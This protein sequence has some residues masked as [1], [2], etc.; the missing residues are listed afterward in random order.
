MGLMERIRSGEVLVADGA[1]GTLLQQRGMPPGSCPELLNLSQEDLVASVPRDYA[2]A[3]SDMVYTNSFGGN[4]IRL[5]RCGAGDKVREINIK[6]ARIARE[7]VGEGILVIGSIGPTGE[8]LEPFGDL[9]EGEAFEVFLEQAGALLEGGVDAIVLETFSDLKELLIALKAVRGFKVPVICSM[10]FDT[11]GRTMMGVSP[12]DA[13]AA[14][15]KEGVDVI[16][17]N[18]GRGLEDMEDSIRRMGAIAPGTPLIAK[19]NAGLPKLVGGKAVYEATPEDMA[20]YAVRYVELGARIV[21][22]CCGS[23]PD[24]IRAIAKA[25]KGR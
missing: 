4:R 22:G 25:V 23:T 6:A 10:S 21:G 8:M 18:C 16:G 7:A 1:T 17:A 9:E 2:D 12:E 19:P 3:G 11:G 15:F 5:R 14:L 13:A 20:R 24:H